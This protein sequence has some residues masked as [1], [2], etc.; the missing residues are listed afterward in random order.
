MEYLLPIMIV[1]IS[2]GILVFLLYLVKASISFYKKNLLAIISYL[3]IVVILFIIFSN[4]YHINNKLN[5]SMVLFVN[6]YTIF[7]TACGL[8]IIIVA[9]IIGIIQKVKENRIIKKYESKYEFTK[10]EYYRDI[11]GDISPA[12]LSVIYNRHINIEDQIIA[13]IVYLEEKHII[14][15]KDNKITIVDNSVTLLEHEKIIIEYVNNIIDY[16]KFYKKYRFALI[17]DLENQEYIVIKSKDIFDMTE[18]IKIIILWI[19]ISLIIVMPVIIS[20]SEIGIFL[21][22]AYIFAFLSIPIYEFITKKI[23]PFVRTKKA[24]ELSSKLNG[25]KN[26]LQD[27]TLINTKKIEEVKLYND[28][29]I[30]GIIF[31]LKGSLND[32]NK[33]LYNNIKMKLCKR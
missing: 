26:F 19:I 21:V 5:Y 13:T 3:I 18:L 29:I 27:F 25:L 20:I 17:N 12:I 4:I 33:E 7:M 9:P 28:Y 2:L 16:N 22:L 15:F 24:L 6:E 1:L 10:Y 23:N 31:D 14:Y 8:G 32:E 11:V 30:Y